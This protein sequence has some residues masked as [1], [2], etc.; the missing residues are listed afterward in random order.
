MDLTKFI[1]L[2]PY[3]YHLTDRRNLKSIIAQKKILSTKK[4]VND[5]AKPNKRTYLS[6]RRP[7]HD[8]IKINGFDFHIRDQ[9][10]IS[11]LVLG[12]SLTNNW[13]VADFI[14]HLNKRVFFWPTINRLQRHY[15][16]YQ[17]ENPIILR[18]KTDDLI[19]LNNDIEFCH[20]NSGATRCSSHWNGDAPHRGA[21]TFLTATNYLKKPATVAEVT[22]PDY[23][24]LP[25]DYWT[26]ASPTGAWTK[27]TL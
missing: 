4:I 25:I 26:S 24:D 18:F 20:L 27:R 6:S 21:D 15:D 10:P 22:I 13:T 5:S 7:E 1:S 17:S 23:C 2:R 11:E 8:L 14:A 9:Q 16:R 12:R 19:T 3:V